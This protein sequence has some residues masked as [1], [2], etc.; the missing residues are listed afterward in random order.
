[1][2]RSVRI[3]LSAC[4]ITETT[5]MFLMKFGIIWALH[6]KFQ[7]NFVLVHI[8]PIYLT[9]TLSEPQAKLY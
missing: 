8:G 5:E 3:C 7:V 4:S 6:W 1:M 2:E 9:P